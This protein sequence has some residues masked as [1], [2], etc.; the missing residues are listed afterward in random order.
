MHIM[1]ID[2]EKILSQQINKKLEK[3]GYQVKLLNSYQDFIIQK[4]LEEIDLFLVDISLWDGSGIDIIKSL[5]KWPLTHNI[6]IIIISWHSDINKKVQW[7]DAW[8]NDYIVKPFE[9]QE[10]LARVR[11]NLRISNPGVTSSILEYNWLVFDTGSRTVKHNE[12]ELMLSKKEK[13]ILELFLSYHWECISKDTLKKMF[14]KW[15]PW[16]LVPENTINVTICN[17][18][19]KIWSWVEIKTVRWEWYILQ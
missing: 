15:K 5:K 10:L 4:G 9:Y 11:S 19:K 7:L 14:W 2:D 1:I 16:V 13:Q 6:P 3:N 8:A 18:R 17:L 12:I